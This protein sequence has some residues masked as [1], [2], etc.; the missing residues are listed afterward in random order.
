MGTVLSTL[1][2][3]VPTPKLFTM[4][5]P[6]QDDGICANP[7]RR[8][9]FLDL[10]APDSL[11]A[12]SAALRSNGCIPDASNPFIVVCSGRPTLF[13]LPFRRELAGEEEAWQRLPKAFALTDGTNV[14]DAMK[15]DSELNMHMLAFRLLLLANAQFIGRDGER[16]SLQSTA[17]R[18]I[19]VHGS[20]SSHGSEGSLAVRGESL[21]SSPREAMWGVDNVFR[22]TPKVCIGERVPGAL[23]EL[24]DAHKAGRD[25]YAYIPGVMTREEMACARAWERLDVRTHT[26][27][28]LVDPSGIAGISEWTERHCAPVDRIP[29]GGTCSIDDRGLPARREAERDAIAN[30]MLDTGCKFHYLTG[31]SDLLRMMRHQPMLSLITLGSCTGLWAFLSSI[32][33]VDTNHRVG[34]VSIYVGANDPDPGATRRSYEYLARCCSHNTTIAVVPETVVCGLDFACLDQGARA[35]MYKENILALKADIGLEGRHELARGNPIRQ[36]MMCLHEH[37]KGVPAEHKQ[38]TGPGRASIGAYIG[39]DAGRESRFYEFEGATIDVAKV[40]HGYIRVK[41]NSAS[42]ESDGT[43]RGEPRIVMLNG[44][45]PLRRRAASSSVHK[46]SGYFFLDE[47][48]TVVRSFDARE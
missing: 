28:G 5:K 35:R 29:G 8:L 4:S 25:K 38:W 43:W 48:R 30:F 18:V 24:S 9:F 33:E 17:Q 7:G 27:A 46:E 12:F 32:T 16:E 22:Y 20:V 34:F 37:G 39:I 6:A 23:E 19:L 26:S 36:S 3:P 42:D 31:I 2:S 45:V 44:R 11:L 21:L 15:E 40:D 14:F 1:L 10:G 41:P 47:L 13:G